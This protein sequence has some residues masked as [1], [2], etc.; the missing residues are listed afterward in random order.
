MK[1]IPEYLTGQFD[2]E[3]RLLVAEARGWQDCFNGYGVT[4]RYIG[5]PSKCE[6][7]VPLPPFSTSLDAC[8]ELLSDL[9]DIEWPKFVNK[10]GFVIHGTKACWQTELCKSLICATARQLCV[11][12]LITKGIL[13]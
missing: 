8:R 12:Y 1:T 6:V 13:K 9:T 2:E 10:L 11:A 7:R 4:K 5:T 3:L